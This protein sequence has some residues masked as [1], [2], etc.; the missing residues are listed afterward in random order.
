MY[1]KPTVNRQSFHRYSHLFYLFY[2]HSV[3]LLFWWIVAFYEI[4]LSWRFSVK[5]MLHRHEGF[6]VNKKVFLCYV[7]WF[8]WNLS[9]LSEMS[10]I[11]I[12]FLRQKLS[13]FVGSEPVAVV[14]EAYSCDWFC[15]MVELGNISIL[16]SVFITTYNYL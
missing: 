6:Q 8:W 12:S 15:L 10:M 14:T 11:Y 2:Q 5:E 9:T 1:N 7:C 4:L 3:K 16:S 13:I